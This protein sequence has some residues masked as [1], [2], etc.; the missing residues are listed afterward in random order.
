MVVFSL[1]CVQ[2]EST[3]HFSSSLQIVNLNYHYCYSYQVYEM[4]RARNI[5][6]SMIS[7]LKRARDHKEFLLK[8]TREFDKGRRHLAHMMG[9]DPADMTQ[10]DLDSAIG[11]LFPSGLMDKRA[12]PS[13]QHPNLIFKAQKDAQFDIEGRPFHHLF[14]TV[15]PNY[16]EVLS[17]IGDKGKELDKYED[18]QLAKGIVVPPEDS[19]YIFSGRE[20]IGHQELCDKFIEKLDQHQYSYFFRA[21]EKLMSHPYS[22]RVCKIFE[23][24]SVVLPG[25]TMQLELP[26]LKRDEATGQIYTEMVERSREHRVH[27]KTVLNGSGIFDFE[28]KDILHFEFPYMR[29]ALLFPMSLTGM[30]DKVDIYAKLHEPYQREFGPSAVIRSIRTAVSF[31][32]AAYVDPDLREKMRL[33]GLLSRD[34]RTTLRKKYG[35]A[36]A[37]KKYTWKKR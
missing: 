36:G 35:Q 1:L 18:E 22:N 28:G 25:Q 30:Q 27:V 12:K 34:I 14:Y 31:S 10:Q 15:T 8:E 3:K 4:D 19:K 17:T 37:R 21:L 23:E 2:I 6:K 33:S 16:F 5:S 11:Y 32:I 24:Y 13:M 29:R 9:L 26:E 7:Y 20:W